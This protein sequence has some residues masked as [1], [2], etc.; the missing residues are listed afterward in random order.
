MSALH[1]ELIAVIQ[2]AQAV[3][4]EG[5]R[6]ITVETDAV[7]VV[8]AVYSQAFDLS[9]VTFLVEELRSILEMNFISWRV[10][11]RPRSCN[12]VAYELAILGSMCEPGADYADSSKSRSKLRGGSSPFF[13]YSSLFFFIL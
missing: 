7:E 1:G 2:D 9:P 10:Q 13:S 6:H 3:A 4:D 8:Q 12:R 5:V 11:Q